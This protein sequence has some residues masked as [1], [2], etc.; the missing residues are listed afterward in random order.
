[1]KKLVQFSTYNSATQEM[2]SPVKV[3][4]NT[5]RSQ[6]SNKMEEIQ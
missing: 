6:I 1:M 5:V 3:W 4:E 2:G